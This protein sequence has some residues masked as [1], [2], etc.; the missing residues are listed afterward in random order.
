LQENPGTKVIHYN[1]EFHSSSHLGTAQK[2]TL[3]NSGLKI[4][5]ISPILAED[6]L[7]YSRSDLKIGD[8][9]IVMNRYST[10]EELTEEQKE[11]MFKAHNGK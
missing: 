4:A 2:L 10:E 11:K 7:V 3:M 8:F 9:L 5:V 1:G 6:E